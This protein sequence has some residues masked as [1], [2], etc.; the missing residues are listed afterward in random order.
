[1]CAAGPTRPQRSDET[2]P[3]AV[4]R[5]NPA[6]ACGSKVA[7]QGQTHAW[8]CHT[9]AVTTPRGLFQKTKHLHRP[10]TQTQYITQSGGGHGHRGQNKAASPRSTQTDLTCVREQAPRG[11]VNKTLNAAC[12]RCDYVKACVTA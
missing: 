9:T 7:R 2:P 1:M 6:G 8:G 10:H 5:A 4:A 11:E 3:P 12:C